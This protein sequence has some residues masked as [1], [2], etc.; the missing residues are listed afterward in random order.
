MRCETCFERTLLGC[1]GTYQIFAQTQEAL[2]QLWSESKDRGLDPN[3]AV[4]RVTQS[5]LEM[6]EKLT[7]VLRQTGCTLSQVEIEQNLSY[8]QEHTPKSF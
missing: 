3:L 6:V 2:T 5:R 7:R 8:V 4:N 1:E